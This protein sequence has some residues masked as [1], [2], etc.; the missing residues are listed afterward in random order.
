MPTVD[1]ARYERCPYGRGYLSRISSASASSLTSLS[2]QSPQPDF[3]TRTPA[4][5][6]TSWL[7]AVPTLL[8]E[9]RM[10]VAAYEQS[11]RNWAGSGARPAPS[12]RKWSSSMQRKAHRPSQMIMS[13]SETRR[14]S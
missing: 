5:G 4:K 9:N 12:R 1:T 14:C 6:V 3:D 8:R 11:R 10:F 2:S 13:T 7:R